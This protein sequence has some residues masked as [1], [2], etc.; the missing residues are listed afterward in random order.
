MV[1]FE[2]KLTHH[3][4][5]CF[6]WLFVIPPGVV[7]VVVGEIS[8]GL[9][10][11]KEH[12]MAELPPTGLGD[13]GAAAKATSEAAGTVGSGLSD[14]DPLQDLSQLLCWLLRSLVIALESR[15]PQRFTSRGCQKTIKK[16]FGGAGLTHFQFTRT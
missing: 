11:E 1:N 4:R 12:P 15:L 13:A 10:S 14:E 3:I 8:G 5:S 7:A 16:F 2:D 6:C 9:G